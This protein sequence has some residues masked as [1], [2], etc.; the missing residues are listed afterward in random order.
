MYSACGSVRLVIRWPRPSSS[1][2]G[3]AVW[4]VMTYGVPASLLLTREGDSVLGGVNGTWL[5]WVVGTQSLSVAASVLVPCGHRNR[6]C[7]HRCRRPLECRPGAVPHA[8]V[9]DHDAVADHTDDPSHARASLLDSHGRHGDH[10][11][12]G[13][14]DPAPPVRPTRRHATTGVVEGFSFVLWA[15]GTWWIPLLVVLGLWRHVRRHWPLTYEP[16]LWSVVFP[17]GMYSVATLSFGKVAHLSFMEPISRF[18]L[19]VAVA[20][21]VAVAVA[22]V[23][24]LVRRPSE[25]STAASANTNDSR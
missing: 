22:F 25:L 9:D 14:T 11:A 4:L 23:V 17:L 12:G 19:W 5:I 24:R 15:F 2:L 13:R 6:D 10:S 1:A 3:A 21:W 18:M 20:A 16:T 7:W 8:R